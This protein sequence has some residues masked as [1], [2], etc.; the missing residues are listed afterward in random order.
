MGKHRAVVIG[1]GRIGAGYEW[2][3]LA[4]TH[5]GAYQALRDRVELVGFIEPDNDRA[6]SAKLKWHVPVYED[7]PTG[8]M[9]LRPDIVSV[10]VQPAQQQGVLSLI[11]DEVAIWC[12]KPFVSKAPDEDEIRFIQVNYLRRGDVLHQVLRHCDLRQ[13]HLTVWGKG[14]IHT[15]C[16]FD[17]LRYFWGCK[18]YT[19]NV[20][21][22]PC[23]YELNMGDRI[24]TFNNGGVVGGDCMKRM[25]QNLLD[26]IEGRDKLWSPPV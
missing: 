25:L 2:S 18:N 9:A 7:V 16:H 4:Y 17:D 11:P 14:D 8:L 6:V 21:D 22:G 10:C 1:A 23:R 3:D 24:L 20:I 15:T 26:S 5:A 12:E 19:Y 13:A